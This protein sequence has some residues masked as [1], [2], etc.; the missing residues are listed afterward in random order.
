MA[1]TSP[2]LIVSP[3]PNVTGATSATGTASAGHLAEESGEII[4]VEES[5][6]YEDDVL[7]YYEFIRNDRH[8]SQR[9]CDLS[10]LDGLIIC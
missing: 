10:D 8:L 7:S 5:D 3:E 6:D 1:K 9:V 4:C 2:V